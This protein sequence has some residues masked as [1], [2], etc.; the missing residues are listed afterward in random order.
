MQCCGALTEG[1]GGDGLRFKRGRPIPC[2]QIRAS[3]VSALIVVVLD[4]QA[5]EFGEADAQRTARIIDVLSI[6]RL[7]QNPDVD[8]NV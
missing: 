7:K 2:G 5:G 6:Q 8:L 4:I 1:S 3:V